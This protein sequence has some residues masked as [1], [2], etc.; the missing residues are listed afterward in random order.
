MALGQ[1]VVTLLFAVAL[2]VMV[3]NFHYMSMSGYVDQGI[4]VQV[5]SNVVKQQEYFNTAEEAT[6]QHAQNGA[7]TTPQRY[8]PPNPTP[9]PT[10]TPTDEQRPQ[11]RVLYLCI[12]SEKMFSHRTYHMAHNRSAHK[13]PHR[14]QQLLP[15]LR[16]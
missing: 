3:C 13:L 9:T 5:L 7:P 8:T 11:F 2:V 16:F 14:G 4:Q 1:F 15:P 6:K 10:P 12:T